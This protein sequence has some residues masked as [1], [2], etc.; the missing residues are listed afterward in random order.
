MQALPL[1]IW[2]GAIMVIN[3]IEWEGKDPNDSMFILK[4]FG[5]L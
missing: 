2:W 1:I 3:G 5:G 4:V